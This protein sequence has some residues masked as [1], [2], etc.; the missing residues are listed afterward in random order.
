MSYNFNNFNNRVLEINDW[1]K[2]EFSGVRTGKAS[3][4]ILDSIMIDSYGTKT[5]LKHIA[6]I[7]IEDAR[8]LK[9]APWDKSHVKDIETAIA[10]ANLG[11]S[12]APDSVGLRVIFPELTSE[13]R[14]SLMKIIKDKLEDA[15]ISLRKEREKVISEIDTLVKDKVLSEDDRFGLKESLQKK[16]DEANKNLEGIMAQKEIEISG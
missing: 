16:I 9:I 13:R 8:T 11:I 6:S 15:K 5:P 1:L 2:K 12:T 10:T 14:V 7:S 4:L 3:P